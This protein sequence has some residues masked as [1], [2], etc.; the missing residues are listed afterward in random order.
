MVHVV[1]VVHMVQMVHMVQVVQ[2]VQALKPT[3]GNGAP[4]VYYVKLGYCR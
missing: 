1:Q 4:L 2:M 3:R